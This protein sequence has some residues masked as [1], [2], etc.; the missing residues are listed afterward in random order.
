MSRSVTDG[1]LPVRMLTGAAMLLLAMPAAGQTPTR[2]LSSEISVSRGQAEL[3]LEL[4]NG[5]ALEVVLRDDEVWVDGENIGAAQRGG[6]LDRAVRDLLDRAIDAPTAELAAMLTAWNAPPGSE[7]GARLDRTLE[8][9]LA[10]VP[11][12]PPAPGEPVPVSDSLDRLV[13]RIAE[14]ERELEHLE[15]ADVIV[16][17]IRNENVTRAVQRSSNPFYRLWDGIQGVISLLL[18]GTI[19]FGVGFA[20][21]FFGGRRYIEGVADTVRISTT[22]SLLVGLAAMFLIIPAYVLGMVALAISIVGIPALL[23]WVPLFPLAA[24]LAGVLG[25]IGVAHAAGEALA[26][27]RFSGTDW[28]RRG[29][30]YYFLM[31]GIGLLLALFIAGQL[32]SITGIDFLAAMIF[33]V[34]TVVTFAAVCIGLGAVLL[35][36]AGSRPSHTRA[37]AAEPGIYAEE[38]HA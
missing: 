37:P 13:E 17:R 34:G 11:L 18:L 31:S 21:I 15:D 20:T 28:F 25:Y 22:R 30:S 2:I 35:S 14:L 16:D 1:G 19:L 24:G 6:E 5:R 10:G 38:T 4:E 3:L 7:A 9:A 32:V 29:N 27:R 12:A 8:S 26:E 36:R 33:G 23:L